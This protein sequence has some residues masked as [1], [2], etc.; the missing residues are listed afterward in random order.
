[1]I[2]TRLILPAKRGAGG[3]A[4]YKAEQAGMNDPKPSKQNGLQE[5]GE[6]VLPVEAF[7]A[8]LAFALCCL[9]F[10]DLIVLWRDGGR[11]PH[12]EAPLIKNTLMRVSK[13]RL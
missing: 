11:R 7:W 1:M 8:V 13:S 10:Y 2:I 6:K 12:H 5:V 4:E 9:L 3:T